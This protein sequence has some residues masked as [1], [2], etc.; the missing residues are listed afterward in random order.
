[1]SIFPTRILLATDDSKEA[2]LATRTAADL[3]QKT[4]SELH[5]VHVFGIAP[6]GPPVYPEATD[7]QGEALEEAEERISVL[8]VGFMQREICGESRRTHD[9][10]PLLMNCWSHLKVQRSIE[11]LYDSTGKADTL[12]HQGE[13]GIP[14]HLHNPPCSLE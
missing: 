14:L 10:L 8:F 3:A 6:V 1:M 13:A 4:G 9:R 2:E 12:D 5:V 11:S 7:L